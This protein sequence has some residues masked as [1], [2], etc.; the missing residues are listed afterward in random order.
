MLAVGAEAPDFA[1]AGSTLHQIL[2]E[3][4]AVVFFFPKAFTSG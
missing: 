3:R 1:V 2:G 4:A